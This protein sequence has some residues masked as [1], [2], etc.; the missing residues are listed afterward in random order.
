M[1]YARFFSY[2]VTPPDQ[3]NIS[4]QFYENGV[5]IERIR[6]V[7]AEEGFREIGFRRYND[8]ETGILSYLDNQL[9]RVFRRERFRETFY[10]VI[11]QREPVREA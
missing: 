4:A 7:V 8:R 5:S 11:F 9:F 6:S 10:S 2:K 3:S 1:S